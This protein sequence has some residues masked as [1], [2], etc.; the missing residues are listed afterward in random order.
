MIKIIALIIAVT[1]GALTG[2]FCFDLQPWASALAC[3]GLS[4]AYLIALVLLFFLVWFLLGLNYKKKTDFRMTKFSN[5]VMR[6]YSWFCLKLFGVKIIG[7]G[8]DKSLLEGRNFL[9]VSDHKSNIDSMCLDIY[10]KKTPLIMIAKKSLGKVPFVGNMIRNNGYILLDRDN[11]KQEF[12]CMNKAI[13]I[14]Q[15]GKVSVGIFP[16]GTR[17][18]GRPIGEFKSGSFR[19]AYKS[20]APIAMFAIYN[21]NMVNDFLLLKRHKVYIDFIG[22]IEPDVYSEMDKD[23]LSVLVRNKVLDSYSALADKYEK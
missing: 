15:E 13:E 22:I 7:S 21:S 11:I 20:N 8:L 6:F 19:L 12:E 16:E 18:K 10:L 14:L 9:I 3:T 23:E 1:C 4:L 5:R 2:L 17:Y